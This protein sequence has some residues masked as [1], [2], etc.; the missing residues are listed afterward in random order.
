MIEREKHMCI[1]K[2]L[3]AIFVYKAANSLAKLIVK[4]HLLVLNR[5][6]TIKHINCVC[7][8][9]SGGHHLSM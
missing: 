2:I 5:V 3:E 4:I 7:P 6:E 1:E 9:F 8:K